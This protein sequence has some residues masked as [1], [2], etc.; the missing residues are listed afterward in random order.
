MRSIRL[1]SIRRKVAAAG[2]V[3]TLFCFGT[4]VGRASTW[5]ECTQQADSVIIRPNAI[6]GAWAQ[7]TAQR[8]TGS[9]AS[10]FGWTLDIVA[11]ELAGAGIQDSI[12]PD[13]PLLSGS[14]GVDCFAFFHSQ[15]TLTTSTGISVTR[16][17]RPGA[18]TTDTV[19]NAHFT[20]TDGD[21]HI[22]L[23]W[24]GANAPTVDAVY[25]DDMYKD[26]TYSGGDGSLLF[27]AYRAS[28]DA[29][30][31]GG[32]WMV[33]GEIGWGANTYLADSLN[34][35]VDGNIGAFL[36]SGRHGPEDVVMGFIWD[37]DLP[38]DC[39]ITT[40]SNC[41]APFDAWTE[42]RGTPASHKAV[43]SCVSVSTAP[44]TTLTTN[45]FCQARMQGTYSMTYYNNP[46]LTPTYSGTATFQYH[47][48][49]YW[50]PGPTSSANVTWKVPGVQDGVGLIQLQSRGNT[51]D[52]RAFEMNLLPFP[53]PSPGADGTTKMGF[54]F[55]YH[56][57]PPPL[58]GQFLAHNLGP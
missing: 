16:R 18:F 34:A 56:E 30:W 3:L 14:G 25:V 50:G 4:G 37:D 28:T 52:G 15:F 26:C 44:E 19:G 9:G 2:T 8:I 48:G 39:P 55:I 29:Y 54:F 23:A 12:L 20:Y 21:L 45:S 10:T 32:S 33:R 47:R 5:V 13:G 17:L 24:I 58:E 51:T 41:S 38:D 1:P 57:F 42:S 53:P 40:A 35:G 46:H 43:R 22:D 6:Q 27:P 31:H 11:I 36:C 49:D 7:G